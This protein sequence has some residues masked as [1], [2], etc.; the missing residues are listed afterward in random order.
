M[1]LV[2]RFK[3]A[4]STSPMKPAFQ[5]FGCWDAEECTGCA[6]T[7]LV[8]EAVG[9]EEFESNYLFDKNIDGFRTTKSGMVIERA[10]QLFLM[11]G[12]EVSAFVAGFDDQPLRLPDKRG[13]LSSH[14]KQGQ[15]CRK[16]AETVQ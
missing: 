1:T 8:C 5:T 2:R 3:K 15:M 16:V 13:N 9:K 6:L 4:L 12:D 14:Y 7:I 10:M 11:T